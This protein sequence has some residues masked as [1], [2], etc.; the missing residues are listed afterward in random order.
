LFDK[1]LAPGYQGKIGDRELDAEDKRCAEE[2]KL[3]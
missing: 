2:E 3:E 1:L